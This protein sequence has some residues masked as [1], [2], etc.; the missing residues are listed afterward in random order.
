MPVIKS[1]TISSTSMNPSWMSS[2][3]KLTDTLHAIG[4]KIESI[5]VRLRACS[6]CGRFKGDSDHLCAL[7]LRQIMQKPIE[8]TWNR[9]SYPF[10]V[11][12]LFEWNHETSQWLKPLLHSLKHNFRSD[13]WAIFAEKLLFYADYLNQNHLITTSN[14]WSPHNKDQTTT[15]VLIVPPKK[16]ERS[17]SLDHAGAWAQALGAIMGWPVLDPFELSLDRDQRTKRRDERLRKQVRLKT[18]FQLKAQSVVFVDDVITTGGTA[19]ACYRALNNPE[20][21]SV[22]VVA[23]RPRLA[24]KSPLC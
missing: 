9:V 15:P 12:S 19:R 22:M 16:V 23:R 14:Y 4:E 6:L 7:C 11:A 10:P 3:S 20:S 5:I 1:T 8:P 17:E 24:Q 2:P 21:F 18:G 13:L